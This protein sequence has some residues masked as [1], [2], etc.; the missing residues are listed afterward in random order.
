ML[1]VCCE[2]GIIGVDFAYMTLLKSMLEKNEW[3][4]N[5]KWQVNYEHAV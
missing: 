3:S 4:K 2:Q 5:T 1:K